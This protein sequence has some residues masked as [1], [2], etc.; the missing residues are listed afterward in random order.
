M[1]IPMDAYRL[2]E[3]ERSFES[4]RAAVGWA[5]FR[6]L[7]LRDYQPWDNREHL[8]RALAHLRSEPLLMR[9]RWI[10]FHE[11]VNTLKF[12]RP[13]SRVVYWHVQYILKLGGYINDK[14]KDDARTDA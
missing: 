3:I 2:D 13:F 1:A 11:S 10:D 9:Y 14:D 6:Y 12:A 4:F 5:L 7:Y 8:K